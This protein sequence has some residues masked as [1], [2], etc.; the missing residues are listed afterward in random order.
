MGA[1]SNITLVTPHSTTQY[2]LWG[3]PD[4]IETCMISDGVIQIN[5]CWQ[6]HHIRDPPLYHT[7]LPLRHSWQDWD[8]YDQWLS[9]WDKWVLTATSHTREPPPYHTKLPLR[10]SW[11]GWD[12]SHQWWSHW[13]KWVLTVTSHSWPP[14]PTTQYYLWGIPDRVE[15]C[16]I[17]DGVIDINGCWQQHHTLVTPHPTTQYYLWGIPDRAEI[18]LISDGVI[19]INGCWQ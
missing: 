4:R 8:M 10:H 13:D 16:L 18:C 19:E 15:I 6:Q 2:Y 14:H 9:H 7:I 11:Q 5:G 17:S 12:L 1:D 3:I